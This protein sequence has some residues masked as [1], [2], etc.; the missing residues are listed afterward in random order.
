[1]ETEAGTVEGIRCTA[2]GESA[3]VKLL[4]AWA[5]PAGEGIEHRPNQVCAFMEYQKTGTA[6]NSGPAPCRA[7][8]SL[9]S[10]DG[11]GTCTVSRGQTQ[12]GRNTGSAPHTRQ[13]HL[14]AAPL[15]PHSTTEQANLKRDHLRP[16]VAGRKLDTEE[17]GKQKPNKQRVPLQ[18]GPV[19]QI[20]IPVGP[21]TPEGA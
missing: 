17:T 19:Q 6:C 15:P 8:W 3:P 11:E 1:M 4:A 18:K 13:W 7:A 14:S 16:P 20:K 2:P 21:T 5:A 12:C 10:G 9:S